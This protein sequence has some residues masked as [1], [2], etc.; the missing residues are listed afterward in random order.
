MTTSNSMEII[1]NDSFKE[2]DETPSTSSSEQRST[3]TSITKLI[4]VL[5]ATVA[6]CTVGIWF[7]TTRDSD[8]NQVSAAI[9]RR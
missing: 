7:G 4:P 9:S 6:I 8:G 3:K 2:E 1:Y 5:I